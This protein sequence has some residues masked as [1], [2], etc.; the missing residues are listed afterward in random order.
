MHRA[1]Q[2]EMMAL[3]HRGAKCI[4]LVLEGNYI[5][6]KRRGHSQTEIR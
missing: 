6:Q 3:E 5:E 2:S 4:L 1:I